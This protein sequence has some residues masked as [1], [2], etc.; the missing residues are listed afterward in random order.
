M[1]R[2]IARLGDATYGTCYCH[3]EPITVGGKIISASEDC[4]TNGRGTARIGDTVMGDCGHT[5]T[6]ISGKEND[7]VNGRS[8]AR[9]GD[10]FNGC[11]VGQIIS[12]SEDTFE[13]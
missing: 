7:F 10:S 1:P 9:L 13:S 11:Y 3:D 8:V 4:F 12:A 5:G 6:I 2:G